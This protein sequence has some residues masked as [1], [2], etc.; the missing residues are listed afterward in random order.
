M[1]KRKERPFRNNTYTRNLETIKQDFKTIDELIHHGLVSEHAAE[2]YKVQKDFNEM[3]KHKTCTEAWAD[4]A[5]KYYRA[6]STI[7]NYLYRSNITITK[8]FFAD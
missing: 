1:K 8:N 5:D 2:I 6:E 7:K 3:T 4:L